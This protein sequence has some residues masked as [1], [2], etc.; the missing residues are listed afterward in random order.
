[1]NSNWIDYTVIYLGIL[2]LARNIVYSGATSAFILTQV[3]GSSFLFYD[4][5]T[6]EMTHITT[7]IN[8][9]DHKNGI[10]ASNK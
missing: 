2:F 9:V 4:D 3:L 1:M 6:F 10:K 5:N 8:E 7:E